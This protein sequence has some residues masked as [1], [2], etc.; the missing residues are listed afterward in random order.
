MNKFRIQIALALDAII[1]EK[2]GFVF[3][4]LAYQCLRLKW[5]SLVSVAE[6][7]DL[8]EDAIT[9]PDETSDGVTRT[10][11]CSLMASVGKI[12]GDA[13]KVREHR[14]DVTEMIFVTPKKVTRKTQTKWECEIKK[15]YNYKLIVIERSELLAILERP[16]NQWICKKHLGLDLG[17]FHLMKRAQDAMDCGEFELALEKADEAEKKAIDNGD[18]EAV[19]RAQILATEICLE[20]YGADYRFQNKA[21]EALTTARDNKI[22]SLLAE[23]IVQKAG[24][25][26]DKEPSEARRLINEAILCVD[27]DDRKIKRWIYMTIAELEGTQGNLDNVEEALQQ[28]ESLIERNERVDKEHFYFVNFKL[29]SRKDNHK[30]ALE[31]LNKAVNHARLKKS[32]YMLAWMLR[33]KARY[34]ASRSEFRRAAN[35]AEKAYNAFSK[36]KA[37][38]DKLNSALLAGYLFLEANSPERSLVFADYVIN[39][40]GDDK[41]RNEYLDAIQLKTKSLV[42]LNKYDEARETNELFRSQ[43]ANEP[44]ALIIADIQDALLLSRFGDFEKAESLMKAVMQRAKKMNIN[45]EF[46]AAI[47]VHWAVI[48]MDQVRYPE[49]RFLAKEA[50]TYSDKLPK[51]ICQDA[52]NIIKITSNLIPITTLY[53]DLVSNPKPL[54][55]ARTDHADSIHNAHKKIIHELVRAVSVTTDSA[56]ILY[57]YWGKGNLVRFILNHRGFPNAYHVTVEA[58]NVD[59]AMLWVR[60]LC[61]MVD[62]LTILWKGPL[63]NQSFLS[64]IPEDF[65]GSG[66]GAGYVLALGTKFRPPKELDSMDWYSAFGWATLLPKEVLSFLFGEALPFFKLGRLFILPALNVGCYTPGHGA[67]ERMFNE[68]SNAIPFLSSSGSNSNSIG[69]DSF[70]LPFFPDIPLEELAK[71]VEGESDSLLEMRLA[72]RSLSNTLKN[73]DKFETKNILQECFER[74]KSSLSSVKRIYDDLSRKLEWARNEG[75]IESFVFNP[76]NFEVNPENLA[77]AELTNIYNELR[78]NPWYAYFRLSSQGYRW[79]LMK[80]IPRTNIK[81]PLREVHHWLVLPKGPY[82]AVVKNKKER[83]N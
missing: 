2:S 69:L 56:Q 67:L 37:M 28:W 61:P 41:Y 44:Q 71:V 47:K 21:D 26:A 75:K 46:I 27:K 15:L 6:E 51:K 17:Y 18:W 48:K 19:C 22:S 53:G 50:L 42:T 24:A 33:D 62:V 11:S 60:A 30:R 32:W 1:E 83:P 13:E 8:G 23:C 7:G 63:I 38:E 9:V 5:P 58:T 54:K 66:G 45:N 55:L 80:K 40:T 49:A 10:F 73:R 16:E 81:K 76:D 77:A 79:D 12:K 34:L 43:M 82:F 36:T 29:F 70:P 25:I 31:Y 72:L 78:A 3:Q 39:Q 59:E 14:P 20:I 68:V 35:E 64:L 52:N 57:D 4:R 74:V 65:I